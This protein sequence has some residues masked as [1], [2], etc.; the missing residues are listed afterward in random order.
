MGDKAAESY[1]RYVGF[2]FGDEGYRP[3]GRLTL[4]QTQVKSVGAR[5]AQRAQEWGEATAH[6]YGWRLMEVRRFDSLRPEQQDYYRRLYG[7]E[8]EITS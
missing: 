4:P 2:F 1:V 5:T 3:Q 8:K 6:E 7:W